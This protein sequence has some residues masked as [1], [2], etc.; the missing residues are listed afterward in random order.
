MTSGVGEGEREPE[1]R[2]WEGGLGLHTRAITA[3]TP[4]RAGRGLSVP[5]DWEHF[6]RESK[7]KEKG[8]RETWLATRVSFTLFT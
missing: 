1:S 3:E 4:G 5:S 7:G 8:C 2:D 6:S